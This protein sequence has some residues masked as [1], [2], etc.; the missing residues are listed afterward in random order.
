MIENL[1]A[2]KS[3]LLLERWY[4]KRRLLVAVGRLGGRIEYTKVQV[5]L[6]KVELQIIRHGEVI[7]AI[8]ATLWHD[9]N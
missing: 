6:V 1:E 4:R 3:T 8:V 9:G 2:N 5:S 7:E